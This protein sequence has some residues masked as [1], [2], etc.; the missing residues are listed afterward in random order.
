MSCVIAAPEMITAAAADLAAMGS[1]VTA[2]NAAVAGPT[3]AV[4]AAGTDEVSAAI[5]ALFS[6]H[7]QDYQALSTKMAVLHDQFVRASTAAAG[8]YVGAEAANV[9]PLQ[10]V[11]QGPAQCDQRADPGRASP[12]FDRQRRQ[13]R[14]R[15]AW[16][17][18]PAFP[19]PGAPGGCCS[20][21]PALTGWSSRSA[22]TGIRVGP[23]QRIS[24]GDQERQRANAARAAACVCRAYPPP[25]S[26]TCASSGKSWCSPMR[27]R[28]PGF[29]DRT[30]WYPARMAS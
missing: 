9:S 8:S 12:T 6:S 14:Q 2:A 24:R 25:N 10:A 27:L 15:R 13:R 29:S 21:Q 23:R 22:D 18:P 7:G 4:P 1:A 19:V 20:A 5:A 30:C 26:T 16:R 17:F 28:H 11:E 3:A